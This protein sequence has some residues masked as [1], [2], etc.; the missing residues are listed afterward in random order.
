MPSVNQNWVSAVGPGHNQ[1]F[2]TVPPLFLSEIPVELG[3]FRDL[4]TAAMS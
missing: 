2:G 1:S 3:F 4:S